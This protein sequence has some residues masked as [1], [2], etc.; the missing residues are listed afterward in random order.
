[1]S[2]KI[3]ENILDQIVETLAE[4]GSKQKSVSFF[5]KESTNFA[6]SQFNRLFGRQK[7]VHHLLGGGKSADVLLWRNKKISASVL[8]GATAIWVLFEWLNYHFLTLVF[9]ALLLG[10]LAQF[11][12]SNASGLFNRSHSK[13]PRL[14]IPKEI[15]VNIATSLGAEVNRAL[16]FLQDVAYGG[17]IKQFLGVIVGL[18]FAAVVGSWCN[19]LTVLY[20]G[21]VA[22]HTLP[23]LYERYEDQ[24]DSFVYQV[25]EQIRCNYRKLDAG[26]LSKIPKGKL[27]GKKH[28]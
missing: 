6:S 27:D 7:P 19:F 10:M 8:T 22:A 28:E 23:V 16:G 2:E 14:V 9:F 26:V 25:I 3:T 20:V 1:M 17:N 4:G 15:F 12:W 5:G 13:I 18:W 24:V 11:I 21:F